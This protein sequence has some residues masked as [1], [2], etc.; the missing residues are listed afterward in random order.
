[1]LKSVSGCINLDLVIEAGS[2]IDEYTKTEIDVMED[3]A[4]LPYSS[5]TTGLPKGVMLTHFNLVANAC[6]SVLGHP[7]IQICGENPGT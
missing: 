4:C 7:D 2:N 6:Q 1:M 3:M 5:G